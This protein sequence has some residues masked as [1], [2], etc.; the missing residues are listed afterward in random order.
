MTNLLVL[1]LN[2]TATDDTVNK[3]NET[4]YTICRAR[5]YCQA[6][7]TLLRLTF[8]PLTSLMAVHAKGI[9]PWSRMNTEMLK[10]NCSLVVP[11]LSYISC[12]AAA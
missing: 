4:K 5:Y 9:T 7:I 1:G 3:V 11:K 2:A 8:L 10:L 12:T 6:Q